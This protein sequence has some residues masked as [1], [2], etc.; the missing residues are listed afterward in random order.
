MRQSLSG[1]LGIVVLSLGFLIG[2]LTT[3]YAIFTPRVFQSTAIVRVDPNQQ[4]VVPEA[5]YWVQSSFER[6]QSKLIL[7]RVISN[8]NLTA[9]WADRSMLA[10][11]LSVDAT[12]A[13]L[14]RRMIVS[15]GRDAPLIEITISSPDPV[16]AAIIANE[17][18]GVFLQDRLIDLRERELKQFKKK[19][20]EALIVRDRIEAPEMIRRAEPALRPTVPSRTLIVAGASTAFFLI[21]T[22]ATLIRARRKESPPHE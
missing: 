9:S 10:G 6:A 1:S 16:K 18:A 4:E 5:H 13:F 11:P 12:Y 8:L 3:A 7:Y 21:L 20:S 14:K 22:G 19:P 2:A 15:Q 17:I